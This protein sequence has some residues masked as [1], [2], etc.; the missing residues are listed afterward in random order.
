MLNS[1]QGNVIPLHDQIILHCMDLSRVECPLVLSWTLGLF[2]HFGYLNK[3]IMNM[4]GQIGVRDNAF[5]SLDKYLGWVC[6]VVW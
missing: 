4:D 2:L 1:M 6:W 3:A 5:N